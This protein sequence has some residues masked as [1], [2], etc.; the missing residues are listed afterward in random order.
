LCRVIGIFFKG[1]GASVVR[2]NNHVDALRGVDG[3]DFVNGAGDD[4]G[5]RDKLLEDFAGFRSE[6]SVY[7][8]ER[9]TF[10]GAEGVGG[11]FAFRNET[12]NGVDRGC[13]NQSG[14]FPFLFGSVHFIGAVDLPVPAVGFLPYFCHCLVDF[15]PGSPNRILKRL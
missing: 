8:E 1:F 2:I 6:F 5:C 3:N 15:D 12:A 4:G 9:L 10:D 14:G 13:Y 7:A 11:V